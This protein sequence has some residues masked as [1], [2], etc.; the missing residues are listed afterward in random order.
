MVE[1]D[2]RDG[3]SFTLLHP[4]SDY[5]AVNHQLKL[6]LTAALSKFHVIVSVKMFLDRCVV[7]GCCR[8]LLSEEKPLKPVLLFDCVYK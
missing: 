5:A 4:C 6:L 2:K 1:G 8:Q 3:L 7:S